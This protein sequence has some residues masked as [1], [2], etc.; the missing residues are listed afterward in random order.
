MSELKGTLGPDEE[1]AKK[2]RRHFGGAQTSNP[3]AVQKP[4][5]EFDSAP[6][7]KREVWDQLLPPY[8]SHL[9]TLATS[10]VFS[11]LAAEACAPFP[12]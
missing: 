7:M 3:S 12:S 5:S 4:G 6:P 2:K 10:I 9:T 1:A 8:F 11:G